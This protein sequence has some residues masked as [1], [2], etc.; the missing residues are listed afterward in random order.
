M[1]DAAAKVP[2]IVEEKDGST[3][4]RQAELAVVVCTVGAAPVR[5]AVDSVLGSARAAGRP[6]ELVVVW[7][8]GEPAPELGEAVRVLDVF[9]VGLSHA[10]NAG[11]AATAAPLVGFVDDD[12]V[13][14]PSWVAGVLAGFARPE[15][16]DALFGPVAPRDDRGVPYCTFEGGEHLLFREPG[17]PPWTVG[18]GGNM[19]FRRD[20]LEAVGGFDT[21]FGI[22]GPAHSAEELD[23]IMRLLRAGR[24]I[25]FSPD[26]PVYHPTKTEAEHLASRRPYGFG[27][28]SMLRRH[29]AALL[30][31]R[32]LVAVGQSLASAVRARD[33]RR[34]REA[35]A[36]LRSFLAGAGARLRPRSPVR[37]L[38]RLPEEL[39]PVLDGR[40][41]RPL[42]ATLGPR[43]HLRYALGDGL[44]LHVFPGADDTIG[45]EPSRTVAHAR[46]RG[47]LW[48][49]ERG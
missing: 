13:V 49:V 23:V 4:A 17:T 46:R 28:G 24:A 26:L 9:P 42:E 21:L 25:A 5:D 43:P 38:E 10:R 45:T 35:L 32:Y 47:A 40:V 1:T 36:T 27:M 31:A 44:F 14:D 6:V 15:R 11:L 19:A 41:P 48:L 34:R 37:G 7:Q 8:A 22:G 3:A 2:G 16:P 33:R 39:G 30:A 20:A 12:E 29:R 18:T